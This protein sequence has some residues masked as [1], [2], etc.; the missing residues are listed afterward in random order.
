MT[1]VLVIDDDALSLGIIVSIVK[2]IGFD[3]LRAEDLQRGIL[4]AIE[5]RPEVVL[6]AIG[7]HVIW[8]DALEQ[9]RADPLATHPRIVAMTPYPMDVDRERLLDAGFD[10]QLRKPITSKVLLSV[11]RSVTGAS[12]R[13]R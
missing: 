6:L 10:D 4:M 2:F 9:L 13:P 7:G 1:S 11:I 3:A 8:R 5:H 12:A